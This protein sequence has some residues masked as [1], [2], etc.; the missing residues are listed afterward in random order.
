[1]EKE[2]R[3][4]VL[5]V[6]DSLVNRKLIKRLLTNYACKGISFFTCDCF[7]LLIF[8][9]LLFNLFFMIDPIFNLKRNKIWRL[10]YLFYNGMVLFGKWFD[11]VAIFSLVLKNSFELD[12][13]NSFDF[14]EK[15]FK[16]YIWIWFFY[17]FNVFRLFIYFFLNW[18]RIW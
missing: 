1:M 6:D 4:H 18:F 14:H 5:A 17:L 7:S 9:F 8:F 15:K 2:E 16:D 11:F 3:P 13:F 12:F 10:F